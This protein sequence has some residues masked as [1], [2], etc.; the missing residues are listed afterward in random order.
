MKIKKI[1]SAFLVLFLLLQWVNCEKK[2]SNILYPN[3]LPQTWI[4]NIPTENTPQTSYFPLISISW[5]GGDDDGYIKGF[6]VRWN[7]YH[8]TRGDSIIREFY[9]TT[10]TSDTIAFE[11]S[12]DVNYQVLEVKAVDNKNGV[13]PTPATRTFYTTKVKSPETNILKPVQDG[14]YFI[15][16]HITDYWHGIPFTFQGSDEDGE[17]VSF[18][19][20]VDNEPWSEWISDTTVYI[21]PGYFS[22]PLSGMHSLKAKAK[23]NTDVEDPTPAEVSFKLFEASFNKSILVL[24]ETF[25]GA[26]NV[27]SPN[28][29]M[30]DTF[31]DSVINRNIDSWD[32]TKDNGVPSKDILGQ[33]RLLIWHSDDKDQNE[34]YKYQEYLSDYLN[35]GGKLFL[36]GW[37]ILD[38]LVNE[39]PAKFTNDD[40]AFKYLRIARCDQQ[41]VTATDPP[42]FIGGLAQNG[43]PD[44][45]IDSIRVIPFYYGKLPYVNILTP[46]TFAEPIS[47]YHSAFNRPGI[48]GEPCALSYYNE[49]TRV[50]FLAFPLY[51]VKQADAR[52]FMDKALE[53]LQE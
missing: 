49:V 22:M 30:V 28:D 35:V 39:F 29:E 3:Q 14:E 34:V 15:L 46:A 1:T 9:F 4:A 11:S 43:F 32:Y 37:K 20:Q 6:Y 27:F 17:V 31:Y 10:A 7:T 13:D 51:Y 21:T 47:V 5:K 48:E 26:G 18:S 36:G 41:N 45:N 25:N 16:P 40:F 8:L 33:Y 50:I 52:S 12:D 38:H 53:F 24:D 19:Y 2:G 42:D 44:V 23:D